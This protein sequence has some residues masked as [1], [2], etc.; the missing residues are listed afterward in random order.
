MGITTQ[1]QLWLYNTGIEKLNNDGVGVCDDHHYYDNAMLMTMMVIMI[2]MAVMMTMIILTM[3]M[4]R[5]PFSNH[6][7]AAILISNHHQPFPFPTLLLS[8]TTLSFLFQV[9]FKTLK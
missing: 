5:Q 6:S 3:M 2:M 1:S 4:I 9:I 7:L 8:I